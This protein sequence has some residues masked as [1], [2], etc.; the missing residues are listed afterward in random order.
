MDSEMTANSLLQ[1]YQLA[2]LQWLLQVCG[3]A[4]LAAESLLQYSTALDNK[5]WGSSSSS[6]EAVGDSHKYGK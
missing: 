2:V 1:M 6:D 4:D 3:A 5:V